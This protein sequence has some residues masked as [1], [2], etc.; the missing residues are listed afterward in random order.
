[1]PADR[2][3]HEI[4]PAPAV[5]S[6]NAAV[7][8]EQILV[9]AG[10]QEVAEAPVHRQ[11]PETVAGIDQEGDAAARKALGQPG[12]IEPLARVGIDVADVEEAGAVIAGRQQIRLLDPPASRRHLAQ[13]H[14]ERRQAGQHEAPRGIVE[15]RDDRRVAG[16][17]GD[18]GRHL[19]DALRGIAEKGEV[20]G[21]EAGE[22]GQAGLHL[23]ADPP[24]VRIAGHAPSLVPGEGLESLA[25][26]FQQRRLAAAGEM[27]AA[28][29][30]DEV[31]FR[32]QHAVAPL[33][34]LSRFGKFRLISIS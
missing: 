19:R 30:A 20:V 1:M 8:A 28:L 2:Q 31:A 7:R 22:P 5:P 17:P 34:A 14:P 33:R 25:L 15:G 27:D 24:V 29:Q 21:L 12:Q 13:R 26:D 10:D 4:R 18:G 6:Q 16:P 23:V 11:H 3:G 32:N 9:A